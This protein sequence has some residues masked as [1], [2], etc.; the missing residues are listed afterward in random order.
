[1]M[2]V[3]ELV[4]TLSKLTVIEGVELVKAL[5]S[6]WGVSSSPRV[7]I[8]STRTPEPVEQTEFDLIL[9][10]VGIQRIAVIKLIRSVLSLG[11][12]KAKSVIESAPVVVFEG[13]DGDTAERLKVELESVGAKVTV[14]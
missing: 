3:N 6:K 11:L 1:M 9:E 12:M 2:S 13:V 14:K 7:I 8:R 5:E 4:D 10:D